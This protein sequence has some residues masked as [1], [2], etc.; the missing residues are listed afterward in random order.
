MENGKNHW[1]NQLTLKNRFF[2]ID[3]A[4]GPACAIVLMFLIVKKVMES[5]YLIDFI[6]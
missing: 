2:L 3:C 4:H 1:K 5:K 6:D